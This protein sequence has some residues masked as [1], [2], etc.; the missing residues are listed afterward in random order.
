MNNTTTPSLQDRILAKCIEDGDCLRWTGGCCNGHPAISKSTLVRRALWAE[1]HGPIPPGKIIRCT[2]E[3]PKCVNLEH[4]EMT[5]HKRLATQ[6]GAL[7]VMSGPVRS[8]NIAA[9]KRAGRQARITQQDAR[10][11]RASDE[12]LSVLSARHGI[13]EATVSKI[14]LGRVR[15]EFGA[16]PWAGL[17]PT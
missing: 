16:N 9:T 5:T 15:R 3:T 4:F 1:K 14:R 10:A 6:L 12:K 13:S 17:M 8:A 2:C 7:G 11:I